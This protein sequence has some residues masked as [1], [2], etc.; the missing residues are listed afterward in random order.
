[1]PISP[2]GLGFQARSPESGSSHFE[3]K[4]RTST[5]LS[6]MGIHS[7]YDARKGWVET[8]NTQVPRL[9][10]LANLLVISCELKFARCRSKPRRCG[11]CWSPEAALPR[12][13]CK[14]RKENQA[15]ASFLV[16]ELRIVRFQDTAPTKRDSL[17]CR[18]TPF[19]WVHDR[20]ETRG[21]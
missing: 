9:T 2:P 15:I 4:P 11:G 8:K 12:K 1:M 17:L 3:V 16:H 18:E 20:L 10:S 6:C 19:G 5:N 14:K 21:V 7:P 13:R